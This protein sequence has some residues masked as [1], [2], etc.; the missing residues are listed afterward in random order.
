MNFISLSLL[1]RLSL[2]V[3]EKKRA[4]LSS[5]TKSNLSDLGPNKQKEST[6]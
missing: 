4:S 5:K 6:K 3:I 1:A 2:Y